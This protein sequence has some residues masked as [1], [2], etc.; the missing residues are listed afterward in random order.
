MI[1]EIMKRLSELPNV[2]ID[3]GQ[4]YIQLYDAME[5]VKMALEQE[6]CDDLIRRQAV[7]DI[8]DDYSVSQS[9]VEDVTQDCISDVIALPSVQS[10][11]D[12]DCISRKDLLKKCV[13]TPIAPV[14]KGD[15]VHYEDI[16]FARDII[17]AEPIQ[18]EPKTVL[19]SGDGYADGYMVYDMAECPNCGYEYED[20]DK[21]WKEP[22]CP[23]CGQ[24]LE[25]GK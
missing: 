23:H 3:D 11:T 4:E 17:N 8:V 18:Q 21:D 24:P 20:G 2:T 22:F 5:T 25:W 6:P 19:Y 9:N 10:K 14:I 13:Y 15:S 7:L 1:N 12:G 16:V